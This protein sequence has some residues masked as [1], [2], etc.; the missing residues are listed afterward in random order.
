MKHLF[1]ELQDT[2]KMTDGG[3]TREESRS[4]VQSSLAALSSEQVKY[5][6]ERASSFRSLT[7]G[8]HGNHQLGFF[9]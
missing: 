3:S 7:L 9:C 2:M 8:Q 6:L 5:K 4:Q 1:N